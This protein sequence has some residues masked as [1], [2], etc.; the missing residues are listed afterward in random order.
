[1]IM[2]KMFLDIII[3]IFEYI[4]AISREASL[5]VGSTG[6]YF[7]CINC[8]VLFMLIVYGKGVSCLIFCV[9]SFANLNSWVFR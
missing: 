2:L 7:D 6:V 3:G 1:V 4:F 5:N 9:N 8:V